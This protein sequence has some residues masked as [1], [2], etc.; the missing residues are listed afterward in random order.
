MR[1]SST[2]QHRVRSYALER[3]ITPERMGK[4]Q[5]LVV[6]PPLKRLPA[7]DHAWPMTRAEQPHAHCG[8]RPHTAG[9]SQR[10]TGC[11]SSHTPNGG[12]EPPQ[13]IA[14]KSPHT[15]WCLPG[16][17]LAASAATASWSRE[18]PHLRAEPRH[19]QGK[20]L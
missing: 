12:E 13:P 6:P 17:P 18:R 19:Y 14:G 4:T 5:S 7:G 8:Q 10:P 3:P 2:R 20:N 9:V 11:G 16:G 15:P 1:T